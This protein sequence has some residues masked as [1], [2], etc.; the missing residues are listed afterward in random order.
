M[1]R[2]LFLLRSRLLRKNKK[3][4]TR[5]NRTILEKEAQ[6]RTLKATRPT[7][8]PAMKKMKAMKSQMTPHTFVEF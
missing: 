6:T 5:V 3:T 2:V 1:L 8:M 7:R 4:I